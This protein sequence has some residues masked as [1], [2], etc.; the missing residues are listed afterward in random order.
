MNM[1]GH[2][3]V[4]CHAEWPEQEI[5]MCCAALQARMGHQFGRARCAQAVFGK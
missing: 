4:T 3:S 5:E 2:N 1:R